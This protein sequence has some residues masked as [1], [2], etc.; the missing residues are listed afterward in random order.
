MYTR[1]YTCCQHDKSNFESV[2]RLGGFPFILRSKTKQ[3]LSH[4]HQ[5]LRSNSLICL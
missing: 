1:R 5:K 4:N 2:N 3:D